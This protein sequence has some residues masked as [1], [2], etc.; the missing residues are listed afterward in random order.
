MDP[1]VEALR[2]LCT[3][4]GRKLAI[5]RYRLIIETADGFTKN[6]HWQGPPPREL[7]IP[8]PYTPRVSYKMP[9]PLDFSGERPLLVR[10]Y[11]LRGVDPSRPIAWYREAPEFG[12]PAEALA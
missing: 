1:L 2:E 10:T 12:T 7:H 3:A 9:G 11:E 5:T 4:Y 6:M 8:L